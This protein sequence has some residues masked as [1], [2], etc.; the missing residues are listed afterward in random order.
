MK[1]KQQ[2]MDKKVKILLADEDTKVVRALTRLLN[3]YGFDIVSTTN[4]NEISKLALNENVD[5]V[6]TEFFFQGGDV[7]KELEIIRHDNPYIALIILTGTMDVEAVSEVFNENLI[8]RLFT[9]PWNDDSLIQAI[10]GAIKEKQ[11]EK[12]NQR[13]IQRLKEANERLEEMVN[14]RTRQLERAKKEWEATFDAFEDPI[15]IVDS[16]SY[17]IIRANIATSKLLQREIKSIPSSLCYHVLR[18][19]EHICNDCPIKQKKKDVVCKI[20]ERIFKANFFEVK[21]Q[22]FQSTYVVHLKCL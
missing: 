20:K 9:K 21:L 11:L 14:L 4:I 16:V 7:S 10:K 1:N 8:D 12:E 22:D 2:K 17:K 13:L 3:L 18:N 6:V 5:A 19:K 15:F